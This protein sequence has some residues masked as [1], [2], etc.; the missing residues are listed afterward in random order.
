MGWWLTPITLTPQP[1]WLGLALFEAGVE[2][3]QKSKLFYKLFVKLVL[4]VGL[5]RLASWLRQKQTNTD[6][7]ATSGVRPP[8][9][10]N[11]FKSKPWVWGV[12]KVVNLDF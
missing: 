6:I 11:P 9:K 3:D 10:L 5:L 8:P 12:R 1:V 4:F 7:R 2:L